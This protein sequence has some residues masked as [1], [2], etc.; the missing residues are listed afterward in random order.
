MLI[1]NKINLAE[2]RRELTTEE[3]E[4]FAK[5][6]GLIYMEASA[7]TAQNVLE[8]FIGIASDIYKTM[9]N[10]GFICQMSLVG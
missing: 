7:K 8:A 4:D 3:G 6:L 2:R 10:V 9:E 5:E 1:C